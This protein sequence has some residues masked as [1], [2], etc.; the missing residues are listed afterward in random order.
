MDITDTQMKNL[1]LTLVSRAKKINIRMN[2]NGQWQKR[3]LLPPQLYLERD[4]TS[5]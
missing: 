4:G 1:Y 3:K 2:N 5:L